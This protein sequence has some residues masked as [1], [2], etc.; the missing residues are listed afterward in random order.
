MLVKGLNG[1]N[2][3][4]VFY[5]KNEDDF[6]RVVIHIFKN[7]NYELD[8]CIEMSKIICC[9]YK[10]E[11]INSCQECELD[12]CLL[13]EHLEESNVHKHIDV[14]QDIEYPCVVCIADTYYKDERI[15]ICSIADAKLNTKYG[16]E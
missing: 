2:M 16:F 13:Y 8:E 6:K 10:P 9:N 1:S 7:E 15:A 14:C 11:E 12:S 4:P 3:T 5:C